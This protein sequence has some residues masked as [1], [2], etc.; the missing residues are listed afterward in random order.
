LGRFDIADLDRYLAMRG[1]SAQSTPV[2]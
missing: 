2:A 1:R